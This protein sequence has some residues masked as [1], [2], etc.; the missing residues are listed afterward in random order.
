MKIS[1][2]LTK[3]VLMI[4]FTVALISGGFYLYHAIIDIRMHTIYAYRFEELFSFMVF[5]ALSLF[6]YHML[7][8]ELVIQNK[9]CYNEAQKT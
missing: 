4:F 7:K 2:F 8:L 1:I 5:S 6:T 9:R 3:I